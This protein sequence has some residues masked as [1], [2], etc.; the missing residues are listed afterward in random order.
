MFDMKDLRE[1]KQILGIEIH[2]DKKYGKLWLSQQK[3]VEKILMRFGMNNL[4]C[5]Q[6]YL[7]SH[8]NLSSHLFPSNDEYNDY[9]SRVPYDNA[10][11]SLMYA[12]LS[13]RPDISHAIGVVNSYM[14][15][16]G[17][18]NWETMKWVLQYLRGT[19]N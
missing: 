2:R 18:E 12:M 10:V 19:S 6:I 17:K 5:I 3:Y 14:E 1:A 8:L 13:N 9:M 16:P 4:K 11:G 7:D 15:N